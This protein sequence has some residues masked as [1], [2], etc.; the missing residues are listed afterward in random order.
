L[1][2][3]VKAIIRHAEGFMWHA[4]AIIRHVEGFMWHVE[5]I[6]RHVEGFMWHVEA[7]LSVVDAMARRMITMTRRMKGLASLKN[8]SAGLEAPGSLLRGALA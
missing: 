4:K 6:I 7:I 3:L 8:T 1:A 2:R 5:A